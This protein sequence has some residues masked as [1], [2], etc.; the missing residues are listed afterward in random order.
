MV[1]KRSLFGGA[2]GIEKLMQ[3]EIET[4]GKIMAEHQK[5]YDSLDPKK[6]SMKR[7]IMI[8]ELIEADPSSIHTSWIR[9]ELE[10]LLRQQIAKIEIANYE[11]KMPKPNR[12][13][14]HMVYNRVRTI[15]KRND[16]NAS[17]AIK[18]LTEHVQMVRENNEQFLTWDI[19]NPDFDLQDA[20]KN[21][22]YRH[23]GRF[24]AKE[25]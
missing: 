24:Q 1:T 21:S 22:Y 10:K 25:S 5:K 8:I 7:A 12:V 16:L 15:M 11:P 17:K 6:Y 23:R 18:K 19:S 13:R 20:I 14:D 2:M 4:R 9:R 3:D